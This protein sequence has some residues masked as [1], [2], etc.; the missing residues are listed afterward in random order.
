MM[1]WSWSSGAAPR[2]SLQSFAVR[3]PV[4]GAWP[5][6]LVSVSESFIAPPLG[7]PK[8]RKR[9]LEHDEASSRLVWGI[10]G[11]SA[12]LRLRVALA[13]CFHSIHVFPLCVFGP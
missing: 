10:S 8:R 5:Q 7:V 12:C 11:S 2:H 9:I 3:A 1:H 6:S 13:G 4:G